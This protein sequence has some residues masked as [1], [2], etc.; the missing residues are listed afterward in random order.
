LFFFA[1]VVAF[2]IHSR[3]FHLYQWQIFMFFLHCSSGFVK[4]RLLSDIDKVTVF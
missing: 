2:V 3:V 1:A 4:A